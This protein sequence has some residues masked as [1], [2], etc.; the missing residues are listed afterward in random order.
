MTAMVI[1]EICD[2]FDRFGAEY[3]GEHA[4]QLAHALQCAYL[5]RQDD[6]SESLIAASLLHDIGQFLDDAGNAAEDLNLD[7]RHETT[8]AAFLSLYF[9]EEVTE[10][11]RLHVNAKRY[12]CA[13]EAGYLE[14]LSGASRL[15]LNL[16]GGP[17]TDAQA[18]DFEALPYAQDAIRLRR[19]DDA[20]K[21]SGITVPDLASYLPLLEKVMRRAS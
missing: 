12:L 16:Q 9:P 18:R 10:P 5:A 4:S 17:M 3:Y 2:L 7:A 15:S 13:T 1:D 6:C 20:G 8:G 11:V 21:Q 14:G 19:F